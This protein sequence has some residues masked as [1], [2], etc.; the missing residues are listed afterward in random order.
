MYVC[1]YVCMYV[2]MYVC[3]Y[4]CMYVYMLRMMSFINGRCIWY[5]CWYDVWIYVRMYVC[6]M[7]PVQL[8][9]DWILPCCCL[10]CCLVRYHHYM[11]AYMY[12]ASISACT[13]NRIHFMYTCN[14]QHAF[15]LTHIHICMVCAYVATLFI[16]SP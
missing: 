5:L 10:F 12:L 14:I 15:V 1:M 11:Y 13:D 3:M 6:Y 7:N 9:S 4:I 8:T 16:Y 2:S